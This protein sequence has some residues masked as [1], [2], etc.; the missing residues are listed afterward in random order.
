MLSITIQLR[1]LIL[2]YVVLIISLKAFHNEYM[3][4][5]HLHMYIIQKYVRREQQSYGIMLIQKPT[6]GLDQVHP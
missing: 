1:I 4:I 6:T 3:V 5:I 2:D